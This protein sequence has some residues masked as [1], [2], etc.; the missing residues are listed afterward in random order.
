MPRLD[1]CDDRSQVLARRANR[2]RSDRS[3]SLPSG[4]GSPQAGSEISS[5]CRPP[6]LWTR[7]SRRWPGRALRG[8]VPVLR[9]SQGLGALTPLELESWMLKVACVGVSALMA[10]GLVVCS[11]GRGSP[12]SP[13]AF[14]SGSGPT[15]IAGTAY[16][17]GPATGLSF[18]PL[19]HS[20]SDGPLEVCIVNTD[21]C[22]VA[23]ASGHFELARDVS[24]DIQLHFSGSGHDVIMTFHDVQ[25]GQTITLCLV[26]IVIVAIAPTFSTGNP[27]RQIEGG[28]GRY[29]LPATH[30]RPMI[31]A[32]SASGFGTNFWVRPYWLSPP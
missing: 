29:S 10:I 28:I 30:G 31:N 32:G 1:V 20:G 11:G 6:D 12:A 16:S 2:L 26:T 4:L 23:D 17:A 27:R 22:A 8:L 24:S 5:V 3:P 19:S 9:V 21:V 14:P 13:S 7:S 25:P 15:T 18:G